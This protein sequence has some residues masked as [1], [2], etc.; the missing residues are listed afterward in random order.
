MADHISHLSSRIHR[1][2]PT[3]P[4]SEHLR[5]PLTTLNPPLEELVR[6]PAICFLSFLLHESQESLVCLRRPASYNFCWLI[7]EFKA[8]MVVR[9]VKNL[10]A[11][12]GRHNRHELDSWVGKIRW[13]RAC[14]PTPVFL[15]G[16]SQISSMNG[17]QAWLLASSLAH[18]TNILATSKGDLTTVRGILS[19]L[20]SLESSAAPAELVSLGP[21][22]WHSS[23]WLSSPYLSGQGL[24]LVC[25]HSIL[26]FKARILP[27]L[28]W[29]RLTDTHRNPDGPDPSPNFFLS[30]FF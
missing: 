5:N 25:L 9:V 3:L 17:P 27:C 2:A 16:E 14:Q 15:P 26:W 11:N 21:H 30:F 19:F 4:P 20:G 6:T 18:W 24:P 8:S 23:I 1:S 28:C 12:A 22:C 29:L 13:R 7:K 10:P